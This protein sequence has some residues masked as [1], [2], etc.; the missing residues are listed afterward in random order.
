[1]IARLVVAVIAI[2]VLVLV[3]LWIAGRRKPSR[4]TT[5][6]ELRAVERTDLGDH[7]VELRL[8]D[9]SVWRTQWGY[10]W[11]SFPSGVRANIYMADFLQDESDRLKLLNKWSGGLE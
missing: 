7:W 4:Q 6:P 2:V 8:S 11:H 3:L 10:V 9:E 1:M 5:T